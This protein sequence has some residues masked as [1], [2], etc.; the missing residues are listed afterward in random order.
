MK[1]DDLLTRGFPHGV[2]DSRF[3]QESGKSRTMKTPHSHKRIPSSKIG[4]PGIDSGG[5][6]GRSACNTFQPVRSSTLLMF[7]ITTSCVQY[8]YDAEDLAEAWRQRRM[9]HPESH[10][11]AT[12]IWHRISDNPATYIPAGYPVTSARD[13]TAGEWIEDRR[14]GK[15]FFVPKG[16]VPDFPEGAL[17]NDAIKNTR[18]FK[19][20]PT[21]TQGLNA[22]L[23]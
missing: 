7:L 9:I 6:P 5:V 4:R 21:I 11:N 8:T 1:I 19:A 13:S 23:I 20:T 22:P 14:D 3:H 2:D 18:P 16:G 17:R 15:R 10:W 12:R